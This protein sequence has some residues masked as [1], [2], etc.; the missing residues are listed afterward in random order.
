MAQLRNVLAVVVGIVI[1]GLVNMGLVMV[2]F[3]II[4]APGWFIATDLLLAYIP[5]AMLAL[6]ALNRLAQRR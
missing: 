2:G 5:M 4:P 6:W 1:G 3:S